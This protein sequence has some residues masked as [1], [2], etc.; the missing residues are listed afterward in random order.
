[1]IFI[2]HHLY[3]EL[4]TEYLTIKD[5]LILWNNLRER[6]EHQKSVILPKTRYEW[7]NFWLQGFKSVTQYNFALF[8]ISSK[9]NLCGED[10]THKD[11][12]EKTFSTFHPSNILLQ[13]KYRER[14]FKKYSELINILSSG[15]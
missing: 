8:E 13:Q 14:N 3:N 15:G 9:L 7:I 2:L 11:M 6:Y 5:P 1:M 4:K 12:L 10:I